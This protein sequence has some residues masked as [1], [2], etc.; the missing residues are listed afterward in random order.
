MWLIERRL[1]DD[2]VLVE[3]DEISRKAFANQSAI[4]KSERLRRQRSHFSD[5]VFERNQFQLANIAPEHSRVIAVAAR[6]RN[7]VV[8]LSHAGV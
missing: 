2:R 5:R 8:N 6:M 7:A 4:S 1:I 3:D